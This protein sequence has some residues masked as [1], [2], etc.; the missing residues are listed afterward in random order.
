MPPKEGL[1][2]PKSHALEEFHGLEAYQRCYNSRDVAVGE[3]EP[4]KRHN[5]MIHSVVAVCCV[6]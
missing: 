2:F 3:Y 4:N 6:R 1:G 5:N